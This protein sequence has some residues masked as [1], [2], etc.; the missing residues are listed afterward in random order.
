MEKRNNKLIKKFS[1]YLSF[2]HV[3]YLYSF[4]N[5][6]SRKQQPMRAFFFIIKK[7]KSCDVIKFFPMSEFLNKC[8]LS[9]F[10]RSCVFA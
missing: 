8:C 5:E 7:N 6:G 3:F 2:I 4:F 9:A 10:K 1:Y